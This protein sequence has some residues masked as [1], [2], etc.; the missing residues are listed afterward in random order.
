MFETV[1][2]FLIFMLKCTGLTILLCAGL[3]ILFVL[4]ASIIRLFR[5]DK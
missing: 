2:T 5:R 1:I 3:L 4:I